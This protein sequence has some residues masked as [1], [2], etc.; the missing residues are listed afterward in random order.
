M[1]WEAIGAV[2]DLVSGVGVI[3]TL[4]YLAAQ[5]R[6]N[7]RSVQGAVTQAYTQIV[8]TELHWAH[9]ITPSW[10][11]SLQ[12]PEQLTAEEQFDLG[13]FLRAFFI[14]RQNEYFQ[15]QKGLLDRNFTNATAQAIEMILSTEWARAW[16]HANGGGGWLAADFSAH[17]E[18]F[19][20]H[21]PASGI[22]TLLHV[23]RG[24]SHP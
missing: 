10:V 7:T 19:M 18:S 20:G 23:P 14:T 15:V 8:Q 22:D 11:K 3:V 24:E 1:N 12:H 17:V 2:G 6:H 21:Q 13:H 9:E 5:I 4:G 16:W